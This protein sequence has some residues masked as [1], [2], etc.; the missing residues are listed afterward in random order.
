M[1]P[2]DFI[3]RLKLLTEASLQPVAP[4]PAVPKPRQEFA[5]GQ[6]FSAQIQNPLPDGTFRAL[7]EGRSVTLSLP[8][9]AKAGDT[10]ELVV[11]RNSPTVV[12]AQLAGTAEATTPTLSRAALLISTLLTGRGA[13]QQNGTPAG[14]A[15]VLPA[16]PQDAAELAPQLARAIA[17]SG[18]FYESHQAQWVSGRLPLEALRQEPQAQHSASRGAAAEAAPAEPRGTATAQAAA[19]ASRGGIQSIP[20]PLMP[21]VHQQLDTLA[22]HQLLWQGQVWPGQT[23]QWEIDEPLQREG[24]GADGEQR[25]WRTRLRLTLPRLGNVTA[26][27]ALS[28][29][30]VALRLSAAEPA[31]ADDLRQGHGALAE[32]L[33]RAGVPLTALRVDHEPS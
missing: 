30:G 18:L 3:S 1:I 14:T 2:S 22:T 27:L 8:H 23:M 17:Q 19:T 28:P 16:P 33:G 31:T 32:A 6:R 25:E 10:L 21:L 9:S 5:A 24:G 4:V 11:T 20:E 26:E 29:A 13:V 12:F 7:V 15:P